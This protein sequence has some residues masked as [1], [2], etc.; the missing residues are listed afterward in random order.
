MLVL[1]K[2]AYTS[3][4]DLRK[5]YNTSLIGRN[6]SIIPLPRWMSAI[7]INLDTSLKYMRF[8]SCEKE[9]L[10]DMKRRQDA[11]GGSE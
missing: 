7:E 4:K 3:W 5:Y 10:G 2:N 6:I 1:N 11:L 8:V 9:F